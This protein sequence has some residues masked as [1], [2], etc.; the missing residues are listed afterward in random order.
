[1]GSIPHNI[2]LSGA[3]LLLIGLCL[4]GYLLFLKAENTE[5]DVHTYEIIEKS[6]Q[7]RVYTQSVHTEAELS[8]RTL[9][10]EGIYRIDEPNGRYETLA[11]TTVRFNDESHAFF[12]HTTTLG[13]ET[14]VLV[15]TKSEL[16]KSVI[17]HGPWKRFTNDTIPAEYKDI[18]PT[19]PVLDNLRIFSDGLKYLR[20]TGSE[21]DWYSFTVSD[22]DPAVGGTLESLLRRIGP[23]G[24]VRVR[25]EHDR[26]RELV[27]ENETYRSN[28]VI[29]IAEPS[30]FISAP[31]I[32]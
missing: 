7:I 28:T 26:A 8:D 10:I 5:L 27:F 15:E 13:D 21:G 17:P 24:H 4:G 2:F 22:E 23:G 9:T 32:E 3:V 31:S 11:T 6:A 14:Y 29:D 20:Y 12:L 25:L 18:A 30:L 19:G 1:M 16:L